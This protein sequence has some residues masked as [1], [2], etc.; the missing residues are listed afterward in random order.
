MASEDEIVQQ[1]TIL[2]DSFPTTLHFT[3]EQRENRYVS[4]SNA[5]S[6]FGKEVI[7]KFHKAAANEGRKD[8]PSIAE[9]YSVG[10]SVQNEEPVSVP[11]K[12]TPSTSW[13]TYTGDRHPHSHAL[14]WL[15]LFDHERAS[16]IMC[17]RNIKTT[18]PRRR[19]SPIA[20]KSIWR[21][22]G[23]SP[24]AGGLDYNDDKSSNELL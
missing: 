12:A 20:V 21:E 7:R 2:D 18:H 17:N 14:R 11:V 24:A 13:T 9:I 16:H 8:D 3:E 22:G 5:L 6:E 23:G 1:V 10:L 19:F 4:V 15:R